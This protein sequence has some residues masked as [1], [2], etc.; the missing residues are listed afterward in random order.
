M[1][2]FKIFQ[3][4]HSILST[5]F[6]DIQG[7]FC[8]I[9][10]DIQGQKRLKFK[11]IQHFRKNSRTYYVRNSRTFKDKMTN[12]RSGRGKDHGPVIKQQQANSVKLEFFL[13]LF[14]RGGVNIS[15]ISI[16]IVSNLRTI[17]FV[18]NFLV[19]TRLNYFHQRFQTKPVCLH[20]K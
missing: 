11:D 7:H 4:G 16:F 6:K 1:I 2:I 14:I 10:K 12:K 5:K 18:T 15:L 8:M 13:N 19:K 17:A 9:F 3:G 20:I